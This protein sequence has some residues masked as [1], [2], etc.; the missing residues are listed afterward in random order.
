MKELLIDLRQRRQNYREMI[1]FCCD[2]LVLNNTI[3]NMIGW[4]NFEVFNGDLFNYYN[5]NWDFITN[6]EYNDLLDNG[7]ECHEEMIDIYQYYIISERDAE[8]LQEYTDEVVLYNELY[9]LYILCVTHYG[10]SWDY[11]PSNW[12]DVE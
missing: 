9:D 8:R 4:E 12:K 1:E 10:T 11:V 5:D 7:E 3:V 2:N 6:E